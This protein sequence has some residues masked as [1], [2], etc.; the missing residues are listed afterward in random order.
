MPDLDHLVFAN[1][2]DRF[3]NMDHPIV[4]QV[5][6]DVARTTIDAEHHDVARLRRVFGYL[7]AIGS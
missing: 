7:F 2:I 5:N 4:A 6:A 1:A 3:V